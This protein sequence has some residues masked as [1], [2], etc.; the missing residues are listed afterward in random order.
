M[1]KLKRF[2]KDM[3][4]KRQSLKLKKKLKYEYL[5]QK[6]V[7]KHKCNFREDDWKYKISL[8][9]R[10]IQ[11]KIYILVWKQF[12]KDYVPK[13]A[14][15]PSWVHYA[16]YVERVSWEAIQKNIH[17]LHLPFNTLPENKKWIMGCQCDSCLENTDVP[18][19]EKHMHSLIQYR[20]SNYFNDHL[21]PLETIGTWNERFTLSGGT[22]VKVFDP[23]CGS[24][25][26]NKFTKKMREGYKFE[27]N[28]IEQTQPELGEFT[29][30]Q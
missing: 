25:K 18:I 7:M 29:Y 9:P 28:Y 5:C 27:F 3:M 19:I 6:K 10:E 24:Y 23:L 22:L 20:N 15:S 26:E 1:K 11:A 8:M 12:W 4:E 21:M 14:M 13:T 2:T 16:N 17:F 30:T